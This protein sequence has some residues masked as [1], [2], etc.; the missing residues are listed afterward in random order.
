[1]QAVNYPRNLDT[2]HHT[3]SRNVNSFRKWIPGAIMLAAICVVGLAGSADKPGEDI[4]W[5]SQL[6]ESGNSGAQLQ[7]GL[8]YLEGRYGLKPDPAQGFHWLKLSANNGNAY[9]EDSIG[10]LYAEGN[11]TEKNPVLAVQWW[12]K[13]MHDG[14]HEARLHLS[15]ALINSGQIQQA[16]TLLQDNSKQKMNSNEFGRL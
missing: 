8:A 7:L 11:G 12:K 3:P 14:N 10:S 1:M 9:A 4:R 5:I 2:N 16:E 6:A 13:A 15:E